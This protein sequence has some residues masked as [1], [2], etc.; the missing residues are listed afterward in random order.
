MLDRS[1]SGS[2]NGNFSVLNPALEGILIGEEH[3]L[4]SLFLGL[5]LEIAKYG[6]VR[7]LGSGLH[8]TSFDLLK[9]LAVPPAKIPW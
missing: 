6:E 9:A 8:P 4:S 2:S 7:A 3:V 5:S 1:N